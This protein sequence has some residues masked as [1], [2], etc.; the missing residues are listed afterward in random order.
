MV[1]KLEIDSRTPSFN[2]Q[3]PLSDNLSVSSFNKEKSCK[4]ENN[5]NIS[6]KLVFKKTKQFF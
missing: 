6:L 1:V 5:L 2:S 3:P 4:N